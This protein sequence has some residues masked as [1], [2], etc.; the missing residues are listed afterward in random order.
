MQLLFDPNH[1]DFVLAY[2]GF[3]TR[4]LGA[5]L[6]QAPFTECEGGGVGGLLKTCR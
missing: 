2:L 4:L 3:L 6:A 5:R 1:L